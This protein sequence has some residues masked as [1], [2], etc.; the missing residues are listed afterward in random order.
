MKEYIEQ[1]MA[2]LNERKFHTIEE[3]SKF[4]RKSLY[5]VAEKQREITAG[6]VEP[7]VKCENLHHKKGEYHGLEVNCPAVARFMNDIK[8]LK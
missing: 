4:F 7:I 1:I 3:A 2:Q 8:K 6:I 5:D